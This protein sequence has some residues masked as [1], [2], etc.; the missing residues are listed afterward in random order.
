MK[1]GRWRLSSA[2]A[3]MLDFCDAEAQA[4]VADFLDVER[5]LLLKWQ[6]QW[7]LAL[8]VTMTAVYS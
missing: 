6:H 7:L 3:R 2:V 1:F 4:S 5:P 8:W